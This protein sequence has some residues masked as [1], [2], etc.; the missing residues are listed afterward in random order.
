M[1]HTDRPSRRPMRFAPRMI[2]AIAAPLLAV[3]A[4]AAPAAA[5]G[6]ATTS[7]DEAPTPVAGEAM[8]VGFT[9]LQ[10]GVTPVD[11]T[12]DVGIEITGADGVMRFFEAHAEGEV[13]HYVATVTFPAAGAFDWSVRQG[14]FGPHELGSIDVPAESAASSS[15]S[16]GDSDGWQDVARIVTPLLALALGVFAVGNAIVT[17][18]RPTPTA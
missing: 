17:R 15:A 6:W 13:G 16:T 18:R 10:H 11:L 1:S 12:E 2:A 3:T 5:G 9:I 4:F 14:W 8:D 7:L